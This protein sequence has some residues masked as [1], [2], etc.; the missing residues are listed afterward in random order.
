VTTSLPLVVLI[1]DDA[2]ERRA[3][4]RLLRAGGFLSALYA[5]AEEYLAS[6][7][8]E[9]PACLLLDVQL[10]GMSGLDLQEQL[11]AQGSTI[12]VIVLT[13]S[14]DQRVR[15]RAHGAGCIAFLRKPFEGRLLLD[16]M[17]SQVL[18]SSAPSAPKDN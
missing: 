11:S 6:P 15:Q 13:G 18:G 1:E 12:P 4:G 5:S 10:E 14:D 7:P 16:V 17:R 2:N 8:T 9:L 3:L